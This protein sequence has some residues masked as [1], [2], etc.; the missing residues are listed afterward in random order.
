MKN[1]ILSFINGTPLCAAALLDML[2]SETYLFHE[3]AFPFKADSFK[4]KIEKYYCFRGHIFV[5]IL[6]HCC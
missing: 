6:S 4:L 3:K 2:N 5:H 1:V